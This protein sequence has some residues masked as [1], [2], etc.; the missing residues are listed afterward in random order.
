M[1]IYKVAFRAG[2]SVQMEE[3]SFKLYIRMRYAE[4]SL[5]ESGL[6]RLLL[7]G[8]EKYRAICVNTLKDNL[9]SAFEKK[10]DSAIIMPVTLQELECLLDLQEEKDAIALINE[11]LLS[12]KNLSYTKIKEYIKKYSIS[13]AHTKQ[14]ID[15][16]YRHLLIDIW[17]FLRI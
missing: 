16:T 7:P 15:E 5:Q 13:K 9:G 2:K 1:I 12:K 14:E 11:E 17:G 3:Q 8:I 10:W 6:V 4:V